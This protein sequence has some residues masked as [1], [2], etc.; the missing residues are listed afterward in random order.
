MTQYLDHTGVAQKLLDQQCDINR[1]TAELA[2]MRERAKRAETAI[3]RARLIKKAPSRSPHNAYAN[4]QDDGWDQALDAVHEALGAPERCET[5]SAGKD[6][7]VH[8]L[9]ATL[10]SGVPHPEPVGLIGRYYRSIHELC[11]PYDH[12]EPRPGYAAAASRAAFDEPEHVDPDPA[13][14][15]PTES[16][17]TTRVFAALHRSAEQDVSRVIALYERWVKAGPPPL[18]ASLARWWDARLVELHDALLRSD[19]QP[20]EG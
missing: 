11:C 1:L 15:E 5:K 13:A 10:K 14:T 6:H 7:P 18:G 19:D 9:L 2:E 12:S 20:K 4:A 16:E 3:A 8:E 17:T